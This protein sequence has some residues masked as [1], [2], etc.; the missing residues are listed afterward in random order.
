[1]T[2]DANLIARLDP[3]TVKTDGH[4]NIII[5]SIKPSDSGLT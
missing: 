3:N 1:M 2:G 5:N 4:A